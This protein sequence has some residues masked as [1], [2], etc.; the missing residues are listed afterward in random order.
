MADESNAEAD[1]RTRK[2]QNRTP[3]TDDFEWN[4][5][6][7]LKQGLPLAT[8]GVAEARPGT[9]LVVTEQP[10]VNNKNINTLMMTVLRAESVG[11]C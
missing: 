3:W 5:P 11:T 8:G 10:A 6:G 2:R 4:T 1:H 9:A 7:V